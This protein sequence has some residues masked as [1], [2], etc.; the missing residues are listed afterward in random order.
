M[1]V[2]KSTVSNVLWSSFTDLKSKSKTISL[3]AIRWSLK[4][5]V[6]FRSISFCIIRASLGLEYF[7]RN[8]GFADCAGFL[9]GD[10]KHQYLAT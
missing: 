1:F 8:D 5:W 2:S 10:L 7:F 9:G 3:W 6:A 4:K